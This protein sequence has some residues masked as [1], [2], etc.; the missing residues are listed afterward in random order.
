MN[1]DSTC[2]SAYN[3]DLGKPF[4]RKNLKKKKKRG[5]KSSGKVK[6]NSLSPKVIFLNSRQKQSPECGVVSCRVGGG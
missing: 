4:V 6:K 2:A 3:A 1:K 5:L